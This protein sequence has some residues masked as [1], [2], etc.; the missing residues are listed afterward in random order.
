MDTRMCGQAIGDAGMDAWAAERMR[1]S[2]HEC[3]GRWQEKL[4]TGRRE[5]WVD[6]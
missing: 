4:L 5:G 3:L 1:E 2:M 6:E